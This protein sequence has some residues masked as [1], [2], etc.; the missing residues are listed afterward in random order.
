[1]AWR[2]LENSPISNFMK[3]HLAILHSYVYW[4]TDGRSSCSR[5]SVKVCMTVYTQTHIY[6]IFVLLLKVQSGNH[7]TLSGCE[8]GQDHGSMACIFLCCHSSQLY[9]SVLQFHKQNFGDKIRPVWPI[10]SMWYSVPEPLPAQVHLLLNYN[11]KT[12]ALKPC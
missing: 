8:F 4:Q 3:I 1:M 10:H 7:S 9:A 6:N 11:F 5:H 12:V 2:F